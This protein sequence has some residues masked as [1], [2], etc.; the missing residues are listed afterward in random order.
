M[1]YSILVN[2][3]VN[4]GQLK[5]RILPIFE[6]DDWVDHPSGRHMT[7]KEVAEYR[8][9]EAKKEFPKMLAS[10][11]IEETKELL[12]VWEWFVKWFGNGT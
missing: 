11:G 9:D 12:Q 1:D 2:Q 10:N 6:R 4:E 5:K 7:Q 3:L 8:I